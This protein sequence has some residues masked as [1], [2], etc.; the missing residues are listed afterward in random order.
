MH[1][2]NIP[3]NP[4]AADLALLEGKLADLPDS[5]GKRWLLFLIGEVKRLQDERDEEVRRLQ[6]ELDEALTALQEYE[7]A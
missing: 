1:I 7:E 3:P 2:P 5:Q 6:A 4:D